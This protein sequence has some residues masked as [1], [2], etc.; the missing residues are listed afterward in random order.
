MTISTYLRIS[1]SACELI[2]PIY[3]HS[4]MCERFAMCERSDVD[5]EQGVRM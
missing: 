2:V 4:G 1:N 3:E 5:W